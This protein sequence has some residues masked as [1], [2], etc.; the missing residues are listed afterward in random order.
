MTRKQP[1]RHRRNNRP[2]PIRRAP[3]KVR[4]KST[5]SS[6]PND[7]TLAYLA[8]NLLG[9]LGAFA[10]QAYT[11]REMGAP[12]DA[13]DEVVEWTLRVVMNWSL[14]TEEQREIAMTFIISDHQ[15]ALDAIDTASRL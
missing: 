6:Q 10:M 8:E 2:R 14:L 4:G 12:E 7:P 3:G 5:E 9:A 1:R 13:V 11:L 15:P